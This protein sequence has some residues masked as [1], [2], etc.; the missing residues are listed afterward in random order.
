M[1]DA[2]W[3][4]LSSGLHDTATFP[5]SFLLSMFYPSFTVSP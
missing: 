1:W 3:Q 5:V 2:L 4:E